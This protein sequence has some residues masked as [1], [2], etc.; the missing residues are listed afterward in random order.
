MKKFIDYSKRIG[1][2][3]M[4][5]Q[6]PGGNTSFKIDNIIYIK[7]SGLHLSKA[8]TNTFQKI[9][10]SKILDFYQSS[11]K[12][13]EKFDKKLS[14]E[15]PLHVLSDARYI[16]H[17]HSIASIIC[18]AIYKKDLLN[19]LLLNENILPIKYLRP[20]LSLAL[21]IK[22]SKDKKSFSSIFLHNH[23]MVIEGSV[24][25][26][27]YEKIHK[28]EDFF[29]TLIDYKLLFEIKNNIVKL[30]QKNL[31]IKNPNSEIKYEKFNQKF[32]FPDHAVFFPFPIDK[33]KNSSINYDKDYI[34]FDKK[35]SETELI[36]FK[37]LL[38]IFNYIKNKQILNYIDQ[39]KSIDLRNSKDEKLRQK[40]NK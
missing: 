34:Y 18:S 14:I 12:R 25:Q 19:K 28:I 38:I 10:Y 20:G 2:D 17:Y 4:L 27:V 16:F 36:Y 39:D 31:R 22:D 40:L 11:K 30:E 9:E 29:K 13:N 37:T 15:T 21:E 23:G 1:R 3:F 35:L 7:K 5:C 6:G 26:E 24:L 8:T 33:D 32:L